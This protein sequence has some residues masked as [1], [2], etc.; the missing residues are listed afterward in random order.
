MTALNPKRV[1]R[2]ASK[3][4][5]LAALGV[6]T[7]SIM[8]FTQNVSA[9]PFTAGN[10]V[11][12][13]VGTGVGALPATATPVFVDEY[14]RAG[15]AAV[16]SIALPAV[17][18]APSGNPNTVPL[19]LTA[20]GTSTSEGYLNLSADGQYLILTGYN[21]TTGAA[22]PGAVGTFQRTIG[23]I[24][25]A[26]TINTT[27]YS[28]AATVGG[29]ARSATSSNGTSFYGSYSTGG[30]N[31]FANLGAITSTQVST[32][33]T[34]TR[35]T[36]IYNIGSGNNLYFSTGSAPIGIYQL[37][38]LPTTTGNVATRIIDTTLSGAL[39]GGSSPYGFSISPDGLTA[40]VADDRSIANGGGLQ[41]YTRPNTG[42]SFTFAYTLGTG[43]GS[44]VGARGLTVDW[45]TYNSVTMLGAQ[46]FGTTTEATANRIVAVTDAGA[47]TPAATIATAAAN[48]VFRGIDFT[49][50]PI[51]EPSTYLG[52]GL[53]VAALCFS[54]RWRLAGLLRRNS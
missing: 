9:A 54:Q 18:A 39:G 13:R 28:T 43:V 44:T 46:V 48:T 49:P 32:T 1:I 36:E 51:P 11:V 53:A 40:Y 22:V 26:G 5:K 14:L 16:Q 19:A 3:T 20:T 27:T 42:A 35:V 23:R 50:T 4:G 30:I 31:Y 25:Q 24:D 15:G 37:T 34:N 45:T 38:G 8:L 7:A 12:E 29:N 21:A 33:I 47:G 2:R 41:K 52:A 10:L 17:A 6:A